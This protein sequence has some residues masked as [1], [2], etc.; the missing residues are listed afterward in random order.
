MASEGN[1]V[2]HQHVN[3]KTHFR[4]QGRESNPFAAPV[5]ITFDLMPSSISYDRHHRQRGVLSSFRQ[6][7]RQRAHGV[8]NVHLNAHSLAGLR[9][10]AYRRYHSRPLQFRFQR[11]YPGLRFS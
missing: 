10:Y 3:I 9:P 2:R 1:I 11:H 4:G 8:L 6:H 7:L 5:V